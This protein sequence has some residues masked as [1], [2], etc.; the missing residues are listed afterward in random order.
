MMHDAVHL[1]G[2]TVKFLH[3]NDRIRQPNVSCDSEN[4]SIW[5]HGLSIM[6]YLKVVSRLLPFNLGLVQILIF[7]DVSFLNGI[8]LII[9]SK[10]GH[11]AKD[12]DLTLI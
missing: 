9:G 3:R 10:S 11:F 8:T 6:E 5:E 12:T 4:P 1:F 2:D 7:H